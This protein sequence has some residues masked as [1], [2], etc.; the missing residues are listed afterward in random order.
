[1][2]A[3]ETKSEQIFEQIVEKASIDIIKFDLKERLT[4]FINKKT[5]QTAVKKQLM[6]EISYGPAF[7][8]PAARKTFLN[9]A[10]NLI[11]LTGGENIIFTS[12]TENYLCC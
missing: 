7:E 2:I 6:F 9:N 5:V 8:E 11:K 3:I 4:W 1:M 12:D 10:F